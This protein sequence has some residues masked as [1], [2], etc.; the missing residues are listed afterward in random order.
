MRVVIQRAASAQVEVEGQ[1]VG[2]IGR[3]LVVL[4]AIHENDDEAAVRWMAEKIVALRV[5][6]DADGKMNLSLA[7]VGGALLVVSQFTLYGDCRRGR[8]PSYSH[9]ADIPKAQSLYRVF[10]DYLKSLNCDVQEG[11]FQ[12]HMQVSLVNDGPVTLIIDSP[13][14]SKN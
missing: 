1:V 11:V 3:G 6:T 14:K 2:K 13:D 10:C 5:Y 4:V 8:R 7:D 12:A 9:S